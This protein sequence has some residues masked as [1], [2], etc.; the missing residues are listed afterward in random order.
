M[1]IE[2]PKKKRHAAVPAA[3]PPTKQGKTAKSAAEKPPVKVPEKRPA[4]VPAE[5]AAPAAQVEL[6]LADPSLTLAQAEAAAIAGDGGTFEELGLHE[7]VL[8]TKPVIVERAQDTATL[9]NRRQLTEFD[10]IR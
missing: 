10:D 6:L 8:A 3:A 2:Q 1:T 5:V 7:T 9:L 4:K